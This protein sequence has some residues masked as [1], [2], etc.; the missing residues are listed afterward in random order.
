MSMIEGTEI[1]CVRRRRRLDRAGRGGAGRRAHFR[2]GRHCRRRGGGR[3]LA[4]AVLEPQA[5]D[6]GGYALAAVVLEGGQGAYGR[7]TRIRLRRW[8]RL[9]IC[10][11]RFPLATAGP[12]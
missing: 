8:P 6:L 1:V 11:R 4:C 12:R 7:W 10:F 2:A 3:C 9:P 5:V